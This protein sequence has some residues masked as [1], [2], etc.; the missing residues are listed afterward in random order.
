ME[1]Q[2]EQQDKHDKQDKHKP[3]LSR[4]AFWPK[5]LAYS[6]YG[7]GVLVVAGSLD[8]GLKPIL[9]LMA[10]LLAVEG[11]LQVLLRS[12]LPG[13]HKRLVQ[14]LQAGADGEELLNLWRGQWLLR[15]A[16]PRHERLSQLG[17]IYSSAGA[18]DLAAWA[19][20]EALEEA[21]GPGAALLH[22]G[23]ADALYADGAWTEAE[24]AYRQA[25]TEEHNSSRAYLHLARLILRR[26]GDPQEAEAH[27]LQAVETA[28]GGSVRLELVELLLD[29]G[30]LE[31][32]T[33]HLDLAAEELAGGSESDARRQADLRKRLADAATASASPPAE[34]E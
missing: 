11:L 3:H 28:H 23:L 20:R 18:H 7:L 24:A 19:Y 21:S 1:T 13:F 26:G 4:F 12:R 33:W 5:R 10:P 32:A 6:A 8:L 17:L 25:L 22:L 16:A 30:K 14:R 15:F 9:A 29:L 31:D 34:T 2:Q 27:L